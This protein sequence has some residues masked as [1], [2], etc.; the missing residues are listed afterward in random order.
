ML[1]RGGTVGGKLRALILKNSLGHTV[2]KGSCG[3][4]GGRRSDI[5]KCCGSLGPLTEQLVPS[6]LLMTVCRQAQ[7]LGHAGSWKMFLP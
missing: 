6:H 2:P 7:D 4:E 5:S 3:A 1:P